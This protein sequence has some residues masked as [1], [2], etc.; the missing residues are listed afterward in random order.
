MGLIEDDA[1]ASTPITKMALPRMQEALLNSAG[2][3]AFVSN[4]DYEDCDPS[5]LSRATADPQFAERPEGEESR[6]KKIIVF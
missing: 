2:A 5:T 3:A 1:G 6:T 4:V